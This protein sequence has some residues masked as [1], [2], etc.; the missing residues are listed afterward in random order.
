MGAI[1]RR[2]NEE[3]SSEADRAHA[4]LRS[5]VLSGDFKPGEKLRPA[6]LQE[7]LDIG[8]TPLREGLMRLSVEGLVVG[9]AQRGFRVRDATV[10]EFTDLMQTRRELERV[11]ITRAIE[12]GTEAWES[13]IIAAEHLLARTPLP[14]TPNDLRAAELWEVRHRAFHHA[15]VSACGSAWWL[16][17]WNKLVDHSERYR[18]LRLLR[19]REAV[20]QVRDLNAEHRRIMKAVVARDVARASKLI[21]EH[22]LATEKSVSRMLAAN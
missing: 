22:L 20:A 14:E 10:E 8:L 19:R 11:C 5:C 16:Q 13:Q 18:K 2:R 4:L 17:F 1:M 7:K 15:L 3:A 9:E 12:R 6:N 21:D